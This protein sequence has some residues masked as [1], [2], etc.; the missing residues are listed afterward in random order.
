LVR[1]IKLAVDRDPSPGQFVLTGSSNFLTVPTIS[2]DKFTAG[3]ALYAGNYRA[4]PVARRRAS[5]GLLPT[6]VV[7]AGHSIVVPTMS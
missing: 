6:G 3:I 5:S 4:G 1:A 7:E 2:G